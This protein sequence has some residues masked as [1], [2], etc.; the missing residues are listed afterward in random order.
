MFL[1]TNTTFLIQ[2]CDEVIISTLKLYYLRLTLKQM[3]DSNQKNRN[4]TNTVRDSE[5]S[6]ISWMELKHKNSMRSSKE[7]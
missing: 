3:L 2:V 4:E 5:Y 6:I 7:D 1:P